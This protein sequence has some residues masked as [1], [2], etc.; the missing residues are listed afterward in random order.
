MNVRTLCLAI[1]CFE[2]AT[3]YE[4]RKMSMDGKYSHFVDASFGSIYPALNRLEVDGLVTFREIVEPGKPG[5][6]VYSI[7]PE[8]RDHFLQALHEPPSKDIFRSE[9]L[10][11]AMCAEFLPRDVVVKALD[12][13][14]EQL[15]AEID[16][17]RGFADDEKATQGIRWAA[18]YGMDCMSNSLNYLKEKRGELEALAGSKTLAQPEAAE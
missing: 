3:G 18:T 17:L 9:F 15:R 2:E 11:I 10:M 1:L 12:V 16:L 8:G 7:T 6:K 13:R 14:A 4:I 5:R